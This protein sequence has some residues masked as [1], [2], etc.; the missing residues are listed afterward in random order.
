[1]IRFEK[2]MFSYEANKNVL[3]QID[4]HIKKGKKIAFLGENGSGKSTL[5]LMMNAILSP[6]KGTIY[7]KG[8]KMEYNKKSLREIRKNIGLVFQDPESQN[9]APTVFQELAFG[10]GNLGLN[11]K[12]IIERVEE[13]LKAVDIYNLKD[14]LCHNL[15]YGQKKRL[16]IASIL[17]MNPELLILDEPLVWLDPKNKKRVLGILEKQS[18]DGKT[19]IIS[20]HDVDFA[21]NFADYIFILSKGKIVK[22]GEKDYIFSDEDY[23]KTINLE[24]PEI[25]KISKYLN[26]KHSI[27]INDFLENYSEYKKGN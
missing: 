25:L 11:D 8:N 1:M 27:E 18:L 7:Y 14:D 17:A 15:S 20:T 10:P 22:Q 26:K 23:L 13:A 5:F 16:S 24:I 19:V 3:D 6:K 21:Y 2:V 12:E 9:F 4:L